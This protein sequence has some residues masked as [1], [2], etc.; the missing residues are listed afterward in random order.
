MLMQI[1]QLLQERGQMSATDLARHFY[2]SESVIEGMMLHWLKKG[3]VELCDFSAN[4][5]AGC[6]SCSESAA[7][8]KVY[9]WKK[10]AQ[11]PIAI[12]S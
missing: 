3:Q 10:V 1:K 8:A 7:L 9:R 2:V 12:H 4:C 11:K 5:G 6:G